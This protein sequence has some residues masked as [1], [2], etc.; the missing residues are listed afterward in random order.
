M[1]ALWRWQRIAPRAR[2]QS[3]FG[4]LARPAQAR[5]R[6]RGAAP[7]LAPPRP[8]PHRRRVVADRRPAADLRPAPTRARLDHDD[9]AGLRAPRGELPARR[10]RARRAADLDAGGR[11]GHS[12]CSHRCSHGLTAH[13][14]TDPP[15]RTKPRDLRGFSHAPKRTRTSTGHTAHKALNC[16][17]SRPLSRV[18]D[19]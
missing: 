8:A 10:R 9:A 1:P 4:R 11:I 2:E 7:Q 6:G 12:G 16:V 18:S 19:G 17:R 15:E 5:A 14:F 13:R 3:P